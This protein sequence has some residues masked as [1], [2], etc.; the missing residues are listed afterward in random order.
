MKTRLIGT[1][2]SIIALGSL[3]V[4]VI[5]QGGVSATITV[6]INLYYLC[7]CSL[8]NVRIV[9]SDQ[10]G[11]VVATAFSPDGSQVL[12]VF[13][14]QTP[15]YWLAA[16]ASGYAGFS[17]DKPWPVYGNIFLT[18]QNYGQQMNYYY[19]TIILRRGF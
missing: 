5:A 15:L 12:L 10:T 18:V 1:L 2:L 19:G 9:L 8:T 6:Q 14:T 17:Y 4:P 16:Y 11:R 3:V 13:R 7:V